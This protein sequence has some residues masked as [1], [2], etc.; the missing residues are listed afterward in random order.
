M[1]AVFTEG[2]GE[3]STAVEDFLAASTGEAASVAVDLR[4]RPRA[5]VFRV[6]RQ[7]PLCD[8]VPVVGRLRGRVVTVIALVLL[9]ME[10]SA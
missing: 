1:A 8:P 7:A 5:E 10:I 6:R 4:R 3:A 9:R 2:A